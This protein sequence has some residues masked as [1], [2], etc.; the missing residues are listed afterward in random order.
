MSHISSAPVSNAANNNLDQLAST[1]PSLPVVV[2]KLQRELGNI[3]SSPTSLEAIIKLDTA[4]VVRLLKLSNSAFYGF[5]FKIAT[6]P[7]ALMMIGLSELRTLSLACALAKMF[8]GISSSLVDMESF[9]RHSVACGIC[10]KEIAIRQQEPN[11]DQFF[12]AGLI[13]DFGRL[14]LFKNLADKTLKALSMAAEKKISI[15]QAETLTFSF[16]HADL[17]DRILKNWKFPE[18]L[19][20]TVKSHHHPQTSSRYFKQQMIIHV[21]DVI[22]DAMGV[23]SSGE[24][25]ITTSSSVNLDFF[26]NNKNTLLSVIEEVD[27]RTDEVVQAFIA[28]IETEHTPSATT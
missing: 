11:P 10:A 16:N 4:L 5:P 21:A 13:H 22:V 2:E 20:E 28:P 24:G 12:I 26:N 27:V 15:I 18:S 9:W 25:Y 7:Q 8:A 14:I 6:V 23:G 19:T 1:A 3:H 17:A